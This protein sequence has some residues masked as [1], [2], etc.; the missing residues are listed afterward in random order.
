MDFHRRWAERRA[1]RVRTGLMALLALVSWPGRSLLGPAALFLP[2]AA[3]LYPKWREEK[4]TL[5]EIDKEFGLVYRTALEAP[6]DDPAAPR[7]RREAEE[8]A[9]RA[10][11]P[12]FPWAELVL[13][14]TL[15]LAAGLLPLPGSGK[16]PPTVAA[17]PTSGATR[18]PTDGKEAQPPRTGG[19][20]EQASP[21]SGGS[22]TPQ[23]EEAPPATGEETD[24]QSE[25]RS[26][27]KGSQEPAAYR[28]QPAPAAKRQASGAATSVSKK[29]DEGQAAG[30]MVAGKDTPTPKQ[31][32]PGEGAWAAGVQPLDSSSG[33]G[34]G[35]G[36]GGKE[37]PGALAQSATAS[38]DKLP[39][40]WLAGSPPEDVK[41]AA[42]RYIE[43][44]PLPPGAAA[45]LR[46]YFELER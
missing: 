10:S 38:G 4:R 41:R 32:P 13:A 30:K 19:G 33:D 39:S 8:V 31:A 29:S 15:W 5:A 34:R 23:K 25:A 20:H 40:P 3:L 7:L 22:I 42:E 28:A 2:L 17:N 45:A 14:A 27:G 9:R 16:A 35:R 44:N 21:P 1:W 12:R 36:N 37:A 43:N 11:L 6:A 24:G 18:G 26:A 46:R